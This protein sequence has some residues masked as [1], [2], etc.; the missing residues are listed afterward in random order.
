MVRKRNIAI[1]LNK[2]QIKSCLCCT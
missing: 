2:S 1:H